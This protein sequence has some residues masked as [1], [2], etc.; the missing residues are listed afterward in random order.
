MTPQDEVDKLIVQANSA[1]S[2]ARQYYDLVRAHRAD[3]IARK[4]YASRALEQLALASRAFEALA[5]GRNAGPLAEAD[6]EP[7]GAGDRVTVY[8]T[9]RRDD[10]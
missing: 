2:L 5:H 6:N 3:P 8:P 4:P 7:H 10:A 1:L 9:R